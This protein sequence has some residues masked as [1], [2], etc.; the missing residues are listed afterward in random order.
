MGYV[1]RNTP[2]FFILQVKVK[3]D[4]PSTG[5][6]TINA[7]ELIVNVSAPADKEK[8]NKEL[9]KYFSILFQCQ[10]ESVV[11]VSGQHSSKKMVKVTMSHSI[12]EIEKILENS[13]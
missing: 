11:L 9:T 12:D 4:A 7:D 2:E 10:K 1:F 6:K 5:I 8:A 3:T 13:L